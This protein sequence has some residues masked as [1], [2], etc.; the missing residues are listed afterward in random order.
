MS[1]SQEIQK[2]QDLIQ[3]ILR[4]YGVTRPALFGSIARG[5][6]DAHSDVDLIVQLPA[7]AT[8]LDLVGLKQELESALGRS[9]DV[10]TYGGLHPLLKDRITR[11]AISF[12]HAIIITY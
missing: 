1:V 9:V 12:V 4:R 7:R 10:L 5:E 2:I 8:L 6:A 11:E 3:P